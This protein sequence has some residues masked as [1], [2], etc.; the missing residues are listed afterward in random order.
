MN[1]TNRGSSLVSLFLVSGLLIFCLHPAQGFAAGYGKLAGLVADN[2]GT[3]LMGAA[4][5]ILGPTSIAEDMANQSVK[6]VITDGRGRFT[7]EHLV[8]GW[9]SL[10]VSSPTRLPAMRNGIRVDA[11]ETAV[12]RFILT[13]IF[14]PVRFQVPNN[15]VSSWSDD[16]KWVLRTSSTTRPILR[17]RDQRVTSASTPAPQASPLPS[18]Y[19]FGVLSGSLRRDPLADDPGIGSVLAYV[20]SLSTDSDLLVAGAFAPISNQANTV[21]TVFRRNLLKGQPQEIGMILH[22][23]NFAGGAILP[24]NAQNAASRAQGVV[25]TYSETRLLSPRVT[26]TAGMDVDYLG[27]FGEAMTAQPHVKMEYQAAPS[28][29]VS[30]QYGS[31]RAEGAD[32]LLERIGMMNAFPRITERDNQ[33]KMEQLNH[34]EVAVNRRIGKSS[35][36]QFAAYHDDLRNAAVWGFG[37]PD[38]SS[39]MAGNFVSNPAVDGIVVHAGN[40]QSAGFRA[41]YSKTFGEHFEALAAYSTGSALAAHGPVAIGSRE[42][43]LRPEQTTA[44]TGK[45]SAEIPVTHT[46]I[47]TSYESVPSDRVTLLDAYGQAMLQ[48]QPYLGVQIRQPLPTF[49]FLPAHIEATADFRNLTGQGYVSAGQAGQKPVTLSSGYRCIRGGFSV[50]F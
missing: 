5:V 8:P 39:W 4:V 13:E 12:A 47:I 11:D 1:I 19:M 48:V 42:S 25:L 10:K 32:S 14:A 30:A 7:I 9:Y 27:S 29:L 2:K 23:F 37:Q 17:Y 15:S 22:Q 3:P 45:I 16:W 43:F 35:R 40:Y 36:A 26:V 20:R 21:T 50:Q 33:L 44:L 31:A 46:R 41:V 49:A 28:T 38:S 34:S 18:Q 24:E 6:R